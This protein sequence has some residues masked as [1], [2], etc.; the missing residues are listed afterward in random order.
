MPL[1]IS[2]SLTPPTESPAEDI[3]SGRY[4]GTYFIDRWGQGSFDFLF[5]DPVLDKQLRSQAGIPLLM[6]AKV[7]QRT[8]PGSAIIRGVG[9]V[10]KLPRSVQLKITWCD[11][12]GGDIDTRMLRIR[13]GSRANLKVELT[14]L[15]EKQIDLKDHPI[16]LAIREHHPCSSGK[17]EKYDNDPLGFWSQRETYELDSG[18]SWCF[19]DALFFLKELDAAIKLKDGGARVYRTP[20]GPKLNSG[21]TFAWSIP[22]TAIP[23]NEYEVW[24][25]FDQ[26][27]LVDIA[28]PKQQRSE[29]FSNVLRLDSLSEKPNE[30]DGLQ[31]GLSQTPSETKSTLTSTLTASFKN[32][33]KEKISFF[34]PQVNGETDLSRDTLF[35][36]VSGTRIGPLVNQNRR[37]LGGAS[38]IELARGEERLFKIAPPADTAI[39][40]LAFY[41]N[42]FRS[43]ANEIK[44]VKYGYIFSQHVIVSDQIHFDAAE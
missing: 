6:D 15:T 42:R 5:V 10:A 4:S 32:V 25:A 39:A 44:G 41:N 14:N 13:S 31:V 23:T 35:Y 9:K 2:I 20:A 12:K 22:I 7:E 26:S 34:V 38:E 27:R 33:S 43:K 36:D 24:V 8:N 21:T 28:N 16:I 37:T 3:G 40:R 29:V 18:E 17:G 30:W 19:V 1:F 11:V